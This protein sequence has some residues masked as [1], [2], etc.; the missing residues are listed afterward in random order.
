MAVIDNLA[1]AGTATAEPALLEDVEIRT[2]T[3]EQQCAEAEHHRSA[4][5][6][7]D[8]KSRAHGRLSLICIS[9]LHQRRIGSQR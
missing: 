4:R 1:V 7:I 2:G 9:N 5:D 8:G 3:A 6:A